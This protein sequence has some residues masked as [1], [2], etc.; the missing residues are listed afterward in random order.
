MKDLTR[1]VEMFRPDN[2]GSTFF[3]IDMDFNFHLILT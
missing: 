3:C 2:A 1:T